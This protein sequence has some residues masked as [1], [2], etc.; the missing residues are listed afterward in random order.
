[1]KQGIIEGIDYLN[2]TFPPRDFTK[3]IT[4]TGVFPSS[5][6]VTNLRFPCTNGTITDPSTTLASQNSSVELRVVGSQSSILQR[7]PSSSHQIPGHGV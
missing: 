2:F 1:M 7:F 4:G 6:I 5:W 3:S